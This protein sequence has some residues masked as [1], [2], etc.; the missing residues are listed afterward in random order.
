MYINGDTLIASGLKP[1]PKFKEILFEVNRKGL[2]EEEQ[3]NII[4]LHLR[5]QK[6]EEAI[7]YSRMMPLREKNISI[8]IHVNIEAENELEQENVDNVLA[9]VKKLTRVP[10]VTAAAIMP[11]A[12][13]TGPYSMPV[14]VVIEAH[15]S[16]TSWL[17]LSRRVLL[18]VCHQ[19][20]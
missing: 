15:K 10:T 9:Q 8:P 16:D 1:G 6:E 18:Y 3:V 5:I 13:P 2:T 11:D 14:G 20:R 7:T 4:K 12:C 17:A 19:L